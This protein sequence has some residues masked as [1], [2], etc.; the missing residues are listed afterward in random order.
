LTRPLAAVA[1]AAGAAT[2]ALVWWWLVVSPWHEPLVA[3]AVLVPVPV[4][5]WLVLGGRA[6]PVVTRLAVWLVV[7]VMVVAS[8]GLAASGTVARARLGATLDGMQE[9]AGASLVDLPVPVQACGDAPPLDYG[10]LGDPSEVCVATFDIGVVAGRPAV[11]AGAV[12]MSVID[13]PVPVRQVRFVWPDAGSGGSPAGRQLVFEDGVAQPPAGVCVRRVDPSW[14]A[15]MPDDGGCPR[16]FAP[17]SV[18]A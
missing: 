5:V 4:T 17:S 1:V 12:G 11:G 13:E 7:A 15:W 9:L 18:E 16:G 3:L 14:W 2:V 10:P 8:V 6:T